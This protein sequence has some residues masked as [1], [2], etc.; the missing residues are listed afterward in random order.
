[1]KSLTTIGYVYSEYSAPADPFEMRERESTII[2]DERFEEGLYDIENSSF[3]D[4]IFVFHK[5]EDY[6]LR[7]INYYNEDKGVFAS[8][9][10]RRPNPIGLTTVKLIERKGCV[11]KVT[12]LDALSGT[13]VIDIKPADFSFYKENAKDIINES[14]K[15]NPRR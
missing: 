15:Y 3:L 14:S 8:R 13:P 1:M 2:I 10:P 6:K 12:G 5:S 7:L 11:L 4:I 9:S